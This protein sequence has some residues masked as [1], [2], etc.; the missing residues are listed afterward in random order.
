[1]LLKALVSGVKRR[2]AMRMVRFWRSTHGLE[3]L[4]HHHANRI[5]IGW[6]LAMFALTIERLYRLRYLRRGLRPPWTA[7]ALVRALRLSLAPLVHPTRVDA[8]AAAAPYRQRRNAAG[9]SVPWTRVW[10]P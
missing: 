1:L 7:I 4:A 10:T 5:L 3:H 8:R 9:N 6:L 2:Q